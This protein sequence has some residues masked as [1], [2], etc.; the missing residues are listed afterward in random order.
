MSGLLDLPKLDLPELDLTVFAFDHIVF[1]TTWLLARTGR[2]A[3]VSAAIFTLL[4][5][6]LGK[7]M[8]GLLQ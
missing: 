6:L 5:H 1:V 4:I 2:C 3:W 8:A 7:S